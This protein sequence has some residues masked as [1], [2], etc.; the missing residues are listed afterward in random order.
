MFIVA[1]FTIPRT[2]KQSKCPSMEE[3]I[4]KMWYIYTM[5]YYSA[6]KKNEILTF[7]ATW[8]DTELSTGEPQP[9][10][11]KGRDHGWQMV[12]TRRNAKES[13][14]VSFK[15]MRFQE[16]AGTMGTQSVPG[17]VISREGREKAR[18]I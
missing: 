3:W 18:I 4:K 1:L 15:G 5:E 6:I 12:A 17:S 2:W 14:G 16:E 11:T 10:D 8:M 13:R 7:A 9:S